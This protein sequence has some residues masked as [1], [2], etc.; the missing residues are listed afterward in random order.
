MRPMKRVPPALALGL[1]GLLVTP[2]SAQ[3]ATGDPHA[4][5]CLDELERRFGRTDWAS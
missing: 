1:A 4:T 2:F 3:A 5:S